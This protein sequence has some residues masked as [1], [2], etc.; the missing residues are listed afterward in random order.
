MLEQSIRHRVEIKE[1]KSASKN[2]KNVNALRE[3]SIPKWLEIDFEMNESQKKIQSKNRRCSDSCNDIVE[4]ECTTINSNI[5]ISV[6]FCARSSNLSYAQKS[7]D[8]PKMKFDGLARQDKTF[9]EYPCKAAYA[10]EYLNEVGCVH[11]E[12]RMPTLILSQLRP[13]IIVKK[14]LIRSPHLR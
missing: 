1:P 13:C 7:I 6:H 12:V 4:Q 9:C 5:L 14:S 11:Y 2:M 10:D 8:R 3:D